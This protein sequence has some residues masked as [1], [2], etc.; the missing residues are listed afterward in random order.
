MEIEEKLVK[1]LDKLLDRLSCMDP[2]SD[3]Y[4]AVSER[5]KVIQ[6]VLANETERKNSILELKRDERKLAI[7]NDK[8]ELENV[9][10]EIEQ[11]KL[12]MES[13][14]GFR[15]W[16]REVGSDILKTGLKVVGIVAV[17]GFGVMLSNSG[18]VLPP[19]AQK[20]IGWRE[21]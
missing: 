20:Y 17:M 8:I 1:E 13:K 3:D 5:I 7:E 16:L 19:I 11:Q 9:K 15:C 14:S 10:I 6:D 2:K 4:R 12:E 18:E 21:F